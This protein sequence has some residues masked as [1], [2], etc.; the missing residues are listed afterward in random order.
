MTVPC[1][2]GTTMS[3]AASSAEHLILA[4]VGMGAW[5]A[6]QE[7]WTS[8]DG[9]AQWLLRARANESSF[10]P[11]VADVGS[12]DN[13]GAPIGLDAISSSSAWM[14][15]DRGYPLVTNDGG[16]TWSE[17]LLPAVLTTDSEAGGDLDVTFANALDGWVCGSAGLWATT[18]GGADWQYQPIIGPVPAWSPYT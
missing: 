13:G 16:V 9:G 8:D 10:T 12:L 11:R 7:V 5:P 15:N 17:A 1:T 6:P 3:L 18:D 14:L 4:C 2:V